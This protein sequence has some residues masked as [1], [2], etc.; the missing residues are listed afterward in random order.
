MKTSPFK[1][2]LALAGHPLVTRDGRKA[3][4]F[5]RAAACHNHPYEFVAFIG[6]EESRTRVT[7]YGSYWWNRE[8]SNCD[9]FLLVEDDSP[10][11]QNFAEKELIERE[12]AAMR[13]LLS[14]T[15]NDEEVKSL[16][17]AIY[18]AE[19]ELKRLGN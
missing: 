4:G 9:L 6:E 16:L 18:S 19:C 5:R 17:T 13:S 1:I 2:E 7:A 8:E 10:V 3:L 15:T 12:I 11:L 14:E